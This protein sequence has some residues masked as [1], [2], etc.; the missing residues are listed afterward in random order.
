MPAGLLVT[1]PV[2]LPSVDTDSVCLSSVNVAV[3]DL[4]ASIVTSHV[5]VPEQP[6]PDQPVKWEPAPGVAVSVTVL[7]L[8]NQLEQVAPQVIPAGE[9]ETEPVPLPSSETESWWLS[10]SNTCALLPVTLW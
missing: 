8:A 5:P 2:P 1:D 3:T 10:M 4:A 9:L 6:P 7:P